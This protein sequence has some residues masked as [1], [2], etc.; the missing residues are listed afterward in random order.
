MAVDRSPD[1]A[2]DDRRFHRDALLATAGVVAVVALGLGVGAP[3]A[4]V[5][6]AGA[7]PDVQLNVMVALLAVIPFGATY[8][9]VRRFAEADAAAARLEELSTHD[10]LTGLPN[11]RTLEP[12]LAQM[13][14]EAARVSGRVAVLFLD[15]D[16]FKAVNDAHGHEVGDRLMVATAERLRAATDAGDVVVRYG[17]DEFVVLC[18]DVTTSAAAERKAALVLRALE[19]P[20][21]D[22]AAI[23]RISASI[24]IT[25]A[26][27]RCRRPAELLRDADAAMYLSKAQGPGRY[28][29]FDRSIPDQITP[30]SAERRLRLALERGEFRLYYQPIVSLWTKRLVG[31]EALLRWKDPDRG[32]VGPAEFLPALEDTGLIVPIGQWVLEEVCRQSRAWQDA[33]PDRPSL[34]L[35]VNI[36]ARQLTQASFCQDLREAIEASGTEPDRICLEVSERALMFDVASA[37]STLREAKHL[38][39]SLALAEF[40]TGY[41]SLSYLRQFSIDLLKVDHTFVSGLGRSREDSIICE[42][43]VALAKSLGIVSVAE[44][45]EEEQQVERLRSMGCDLAQGYWFS[46]PQPAAV[47]ETLLTEDGNAQEWRPRVAA[48]HDSDRGAVDDDAARVPSD[49]FATGLGAVDTDR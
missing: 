43:I 6:W 19:E 13:T 38:G 8:Y 20:V 24:G 5:D 46:H 30:S 22:D 34:N 29:L 28:A 27:Q 40:G 18:P 14:Q 42:H 15:L 16:G 23:L 36:S 47:I 49:R 10:S 11:R 37:W 3:G 35:K 39:V 7:L 31:V 1:T 41:S 2:T 26:E 32:M 25:V 45:V 12:T 4:F 9:A 17:G 48:A 33:F 44:G 21:E